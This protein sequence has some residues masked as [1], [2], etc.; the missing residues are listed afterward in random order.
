MGGKTTRETVRYDYDGAQVLVTG[1]TS[2]IGEAIARAY[3]A[4]GAEVTITGTRDRASEYPGQ[5]F[6]GLRY[7][8]LD[9]RDA[10]A[11]ERVARSMAGLDILINNAGAAFPGG[12]DEHDPDVFEEALRLNLV[13]A[14][15]MA[16]ACHG[17]LAASRLA[18][19]ASVIG[20]ASMTSFFG[21]ELVPGYGAAKAG[22]AQLTKSLAIEWADHGIRVNA[23]AAGLIRSR[24]TTAMLADDALSAPYLARTPLG[25]VGRPEEI[26]GAVLFLTS[27]AAT[28][29]TGTTLVVDGGFSIRG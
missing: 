16:R 10:P 19:G 27:T 1:G 29:V 9:A 5:D 2:G 21:L 6:G 8:S 15:R 3:A 18:G 17:K 28:F 13:S 7:L 24:M 25:R 26:A 23:V 4:A 20:I 11:I 22:L 14:Y 12:R